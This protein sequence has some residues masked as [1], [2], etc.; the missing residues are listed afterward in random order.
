MNP[1]ERENA[2]SATAAQSICASDR[3]ERSRVGVTTLRLLM[4][5]SPHIPLVLALGAL[6]ACADSAVPPTALLA[7]HSI[8]TSSDRKSVV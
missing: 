3:W 5:H 6:T 4:R 8:A 2:T 1:A 7:P